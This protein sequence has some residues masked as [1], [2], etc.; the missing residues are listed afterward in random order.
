MQQ[1]DACSA[2]RR[3]CGTVRPAGCI[4]A[5]ASPEDGDGSGPCSDPTCCVLALSGTLPSVAGVDHR[6]VVTE[7]ESAS[8]PVL[9]LVPVSSASTALAREE[10]RGEGRV[11][12]GKEVGVGVGGGT[13]Q[14]RK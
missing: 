7:A 8:V 13:P 2:A 11:V 14:C 3:T 9:H 5:A 10:R 1:F 12:V 4:T 6:A